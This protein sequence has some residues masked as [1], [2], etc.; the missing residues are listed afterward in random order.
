[1]AEPSSSHGQ[2]STNSAAEK[3]PSGSPLPFQRAAIVKSPFLHEPTILRMTGRQRVDTVRMAMSAGETVN[4]SFFGYVFH[5][6][7]GI[8]V[9]LEGVELMKKHWMGRKHKEKVRMIGLW[10]FN[11]PVC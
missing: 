8:D 4:A 1:M 10:C 9:I 11:L 6:P 3:P 2:K 7:G 5:N